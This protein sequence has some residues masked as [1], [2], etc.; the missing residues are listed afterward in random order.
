MQCFFCRL[1]IEKVSVSDEGNYCCRAS[2]DLSLE[3][4]NWVEVSVHQPA[5]GMAFPVVERAPY[6]QFFL[7]SFS[8]STIWRKR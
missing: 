1:I 2:N 3:F 8:A 6:N 4:S 7:P 5:R